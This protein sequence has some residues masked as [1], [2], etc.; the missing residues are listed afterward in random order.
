VA[1]EQGELY[2]P[3][4]RQLALLDRDARHRALHHLDVGGGHSA[5]PDV[6][7]YAPQG[8]L[9]YSFIETVAAMH[10]FYLIRAIGGALF[11]IGAPSRWSMVSGPTRR[12][13]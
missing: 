4:A 6:A 1:L 8:A 13:S 5:G 11:L 10:P 12:W 9:E 7:R 2:S 3:P